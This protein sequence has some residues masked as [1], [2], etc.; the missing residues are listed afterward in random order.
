MVG[1]YVINVRTKRVRYVINLERNISVLKGDSGT[2]K[3]TLIQMLWEYQQRGVSSGIH[4]SVTNNADIRILND[5]NTIDYVLDTCT[6]KNVVLF[7]DE[8]MSS[9]LSDNTILSKINNSGCY[10]VFVTRHKLEERRGNG[11]G[12]LTFSISS[13]YVIKTKREGNYYSNTFIQRYNDV[14]TPVSPNI[15]VTE[16]SKS[17]HD[18]ISRVVKRETITS[19]GKDNMRNTVI[20]LLEKS[21]SDVIYCI[22]DGAAFGSCIEGLMRI[23]CE[24]NVYIFSPES[25]EYMVLATSVFKRFLTDELTN[26]SKYVDSMKFLSWE[27]YYTDLLEHLCKNYGENVVY[28][29]RKWNNLPGIFKTT[30]FL[31]EIAGMLKDL[32]ADVIIEE[33]K[34]K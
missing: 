6:G 34:P 17:G 22:V 2:G 9:V 11:Y 1:S 7:M 16:D 5:L 23:A 20:R 15:I 18:I 30:R 12:G 28:E 10:F 21:K 19:N 3:T 25:F 31:T 29:K 24:N 33:F 26:T 13:L 14:L 8:S 32:N 4:V 27:R